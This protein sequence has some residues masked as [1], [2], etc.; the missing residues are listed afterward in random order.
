[1][2]QVQ[3]IPAQCRAE[4]G[5]LSGKG[6][7]EEKRK[8]EKVDKELEKFTV[9]GK[10]VSGNS[11]SPR[12]TCSLEHRAQADVNING[13]NEE[14]IKSCPVYGSMERGQAFSCPFGWKYFIKAVKIFVLS[15]GAEQKKK[16]HADKIQI[17]VHNEAPW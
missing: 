16:P 10:S 12:R 6:K 3:F 9:M 4:K 11:I 15:S 5:R 7:V 13:C 2:K 8:T 1:V 17:P 14:M